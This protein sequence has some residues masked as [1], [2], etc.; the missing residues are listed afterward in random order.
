MYKCPVRIYVGH[1]ETDLHRSDQ[2][3]LLYLLCGAQHL[4]ET[5]Y[6]SKV[7]AVR[8]LGGWEELIKVYGLFQNQILGDVTRCLS[9]QIYFYFQIIS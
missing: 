6:S 7:I 5:A 8:R 4:V 3:R 1:W 2:E 9:M